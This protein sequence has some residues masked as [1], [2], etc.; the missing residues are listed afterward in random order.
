MGGG[1]LELS[2]AVPTW[3]E[4]RLLPGLLERLCDPGDA[5]DE[6][7]VADGGSQDGT[8]RLATDAGARLVRSRRCGRPTPIQRCSRPRCTS[9]SRRTAGSTVASS[10]PPTR[11]RGRWRV[12]PGHAV[13]GRRGRAAPARGGAARARRRC[14]AARF[15]AALGA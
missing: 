4:A 10:V 12:P 6:V 2:V 7:V 8:V 11:V 14:A 15:A 3:N 13:R 5:A 1:R 9:A